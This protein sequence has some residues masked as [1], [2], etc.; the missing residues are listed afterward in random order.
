MPAISE[1]YQSLEY[2]PAPESSTE[3]TA[4]L[5]GHERDFKLFIG[6]VWVKAGSSFETVNP[7]TK[8]VLAKVAQGSSTCL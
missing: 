5:E 4:W 8:E 7:A 2:G 6:G 1:I 3:A